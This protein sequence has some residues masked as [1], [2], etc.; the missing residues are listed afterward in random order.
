[1][2][3][4]AEICGRRQNAMENTMKLVGQQKPL[5]HAGMAMLAYCIGAHFTFY[6]KH[7]NMLAYE[8]WSWEGVHNTVPREAVYQHLEERLKQ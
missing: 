5:M 6:G 7:G 4:Q 3:W 2:P 1:M 8:I